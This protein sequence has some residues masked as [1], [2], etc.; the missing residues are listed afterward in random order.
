MRGQASAAY[1][2]VINLIG[3]GCGPVIVP[4]ISDHVLQDPKQLRLAL[5]IVCA[6]CCTT[7]AILLSVLRPIYARRVREAAQWR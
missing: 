3:L 5:A 4:I 1:L 7:S 6:V 2:L